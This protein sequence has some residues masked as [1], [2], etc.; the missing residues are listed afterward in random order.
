MTAQPSG[1]PLPPRLV[2]PFSSIWLGDKI[3]SGS[4]GAVFAGT[5]LDTNEDVA[6]KELTGP[7]AMSACERE[8]GKHMKLHHRNVIRVCGVSEDRKHGHAYIVTELAP[9]GSLAV[10]LASHPLR[11]DWATLVR[12]ALDIANGLQYLHSCDP[13]VLHL[14]LKPQ[15]VL[16]FDDDTAKLC[17]FGIA[18]IVKHTR[19]FQTAE[20][21]T[22]QYA[23]PEQFDKLPISS[24]TDVYA[25]GGVLFKMIAKQ[26]PWDGL[27]LL[28][29]AG[30]LAAGKKLL[31][32]S[33]LPNGCPERLA[34]I[35]QRCLRLDPQRRAK[36]SSV[37]EDLTQVR[38]DLCSQHPPR[39]VAQQFARDPLPS[40]GRLADYSMPRS[41]LQEVLLQF[42][43]C[44]APPG[45]TDLAKW[46]KPTLE[47]IADEYSRVAYFIPRSKFGSDRDHEDAMAVGLYT[48][49][50]FVYWLTNAW[51]NDLSA[52]RE[53][54]LRH[55]GPF[56][57]RLVEALPRCCARY[58]GEAVRV[59]KACSDSPQV[60]RDAFADYE[61][62]LA[63]GSVLNFRGFAS[64]S[65]G[66]KAN[67][68]FIWGES[69][70]LYCRA[71]DAFDVDRY[72]MVRLAGGH[73]EQEVLCLP[74]RS[75]R[76]SR[77]P[78]QAELIVTVHIDV[79]QGHP[80][81]LMTTR[82][83]ERLVIQHHECRHAYGEDNWSILRS[84]AV[85]VGS[86]ADAII[87][88][89]FISEAARELERAVCCTH[90]RHLVLIQPDD[91]HLTQLQTAAREFETIALVDAE[92]C[93]AE[94]L[95]ATLARPSATQ[96]IAVTRSSNL[97]VQTLSGIASKNVQLQSLI[98]RGC[99]Q[100][101]DAA[102][103]EVAAKCPSLRSLNI[104][105][106]RDLS[107]AGLIEAASKCP[108]LQSLNI[109]GCERITDACIK[110]TAA[111]CRQLQSLDVRNCALLS[112]AS[113]EEIA[114]KCEQLMSL[115][116]RGCTKLTD[117]SV[118]AISARCHW[119]KSLNISRC[120][121]LTNACVKELAAHS[122]YLQSLNVSWCEQLSGGGVKEVAKC[123]LLQS[124]NLRGLHLEDGV[125]EEIAVNCQQLESLNVSCCSCITDVSV[126]AI[127]AYCSQL[128]SLNLGM[129]EHITNASLTKIAANCPQLRFL[130]LRNCTCITDACVS[131]L[132]AHCP[133][134]RSLVLRGCKQVTSEGIAIIA[135]GCPLLQSLDAHSCE[136]LTDASI[137]EIATKCNQ[138]QLLNLTG[139]IH[140]TDASVREIASCCPTLSSLEVGGCIHITDTSVKEIAAKCPQLVSLNISGCTC[141]TDASVAEVAAK[142]RLLDSLDISQ[143]EQLTDACIKDLSAKCQRLVSLNVRG[144][145]Q[146]SD[147]FLQQID[148]SDSQL[149]LQM[150]C[151][152]SPKEPAP[153]SAP[154]SYLGGVVGAV[155]SVAG[156]V[157]AAGA[158]GVGRVV[159][160]VGSVGGAVG[161]LLWS[162]R[163]R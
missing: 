141:L 132:A 47:A 126:I 72:S 56:M 46:E 157:G 11:N 101:T 115:N 22:P 159:G 151:V 37:I 136:R 120:T 4:C 35:A 39:I 8:C 105:G 24:A 75:F 143:C 142:C 103:R 67:S 85:G 128:Q 161:T 96:C 64:F 82:E 19:T 34:V 152:V 43:E 18:H 162:W 108:M 17:D 32:P 98:L 58:T 80:T 93:S 116:V 133:L 107:D 73:T 87:I 69:I 42:A 104:T 119:L 95:R 31:L 78:T 140:I 99:K 158:A 156:V 1:V 79:Q 74:S 6:I 154:P 33:P 71:I 144:C 13:P 83:L 51:A 45:R 2:I 118:R 23:A 155:G 111:N 124:L 121:Q 100:L 40:D 90:I 65:R 27:T 125:I 76:V 26:D 61:R 89:C 36:L 109:G 7:E 20:Q 97:D 14:D 130:D 21:Y 10:A 3:A 12:W 113:I 62:Q 54:G 163:R 25:F 88:N 92:A 138:L 160:A 153:S 91:A 68:G 114:D 55:V 9:R 147:T 49:E 149:Q 44:P 28:Q 110:E 148:A 117:A 123:S 84:M 53:H 29:V 112:D 102:A 38:S 139:C 129:C 63:E 59:L 16:L 57:W 86:C 30:A 134:L 150:D 145:R 66:S 5:L 127:A 41:S 15:N 60:M 122:S 48:D 146:L 106:L 52:E 50:S 137:I 81:G 77:S 131:E 94:T 70:V 135:A